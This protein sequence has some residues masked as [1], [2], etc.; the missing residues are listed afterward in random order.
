MGLFTNRQVYA[1]KWTVKSVSDISEEDAKL[2]T[3][4]RIVPSEFG[5]SMEFTMVSGGLCF[6]PMDTECPHKVGDEY[7]PE[8]LE[9]VILQRLGDADIERIRIKQ[10]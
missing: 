10:K 1:Q 9:V 8:E 6:I 7:L 5:T 2:F 4:G 3:K